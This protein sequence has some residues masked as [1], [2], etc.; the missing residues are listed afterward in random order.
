[1][2][3][4]SAQSLHNAQDREREKLVAIGVRAGARVGL[5]ARVAAIKAWRNGDNVAVAI[6]RAM[7]TAI[8]LVQDSMASGHLAG[9][10]RVLLNTPKVRRRVA[11]FD[12]S[13]F[14]AII[15][16]LAENLDVTPQRQA[17]IQSQYRIPAQ[18]AIQRAANDLV[19]KVQA[20]V[21]EAVA[22]NLHTNAG[23]DLIR[24]AFDSAGVVPAANYQL[25]AVFRTTTGIAYGAGR[26]SKNQEPAMQEVL[27]GFEYVTAGDDRVRPEHERLDG[28]RMTKDDPRWSQY[29]P[30]VP[31]SP[32]NC[33]CDTV[34]IYVDEPD[35][36][37]VNVP[38]GAFDGLNGQ[39]SPYGSPLQW[40][41]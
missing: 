6:H 36:A 25:E 21:N 3:S 31:S 38:D 30:P 11:Q 12:R 1:M 26:W 29:W 28:L 13:P 27:W 2:P 35:L 17:A 24:Q 9:E 40:A 10:R 37:S 33:R 16:T 15:D 32:W 19:D 14:L 18:E 22:T 20:A 4:R 34:E 23:I 39:G 41:V 5:A 8:P 7:R